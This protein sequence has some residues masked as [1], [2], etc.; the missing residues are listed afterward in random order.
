MCCAG[1]EGVAVMYKPKRA[2]YVL[3][4]TAYKRPRF[5]SWMMLGARRT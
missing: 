2:N 3:K 4:L 1:A 5:G